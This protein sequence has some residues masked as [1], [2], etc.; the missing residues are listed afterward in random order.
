MTG[1]LPFDDENIRNLL[2][3]VQAGNFEM[4]VDEVSREARDL[5]A[6]MLEVDPMRRISTEKS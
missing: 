1:R 4:P 5:I 6:R 2:L 3:K